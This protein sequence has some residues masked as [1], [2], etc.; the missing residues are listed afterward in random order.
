MEK[1]EDGVRGRCDREISMEVK[2]NTVV[3][4]AMMYS[5]ET[6]KKAQE[7]KLDVAEMRMFR[8]TCGVT[9]MNGIQDVSC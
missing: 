1:L 3:R 8:W 2:E 9:M 4:T 5:A 7:K 6:A